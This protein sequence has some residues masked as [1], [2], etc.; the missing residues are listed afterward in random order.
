ME[1]SR[2]QRALPTRSPAA[3]GGEPPGRSQLERRTFR[4]ISSLAVGNQTT[5]CCAAPKLNR[6]L[7]LNQ[8][9]SGN[10]ALATQLVAIFRPIPT[11]DSGPCSDQSDTAMN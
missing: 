9:T 2:D 6:A 1:G 8:T 5:N 7:L 10:Q 11:S 4:T 3:G